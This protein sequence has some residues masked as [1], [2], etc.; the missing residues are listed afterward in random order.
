MRHHHRKRG[1]LG[2]LDRAAAATGTSTQRLL[3]Q[4]VQQLLRLASSTS[5]PRARNRIATAARPAPDALTCVAAAGAA[6]GSAPAAPTNEP[7]GSA[8]PPSAAPAAS[9]TRSTD[10]HATRRGRLATRLTAESRLDAE[11]TFTVRDA[12]ARR[13]VMSGWFVPSAR[14]RVAGAGRG[15]EA[16]P[17]LPARGAWLAV[18]TEPPRRRGGGGLRPPLE[19]PDAFGLGGYEHGRYASLTAPDRCCLRRGPRWVP[20]LHAPHGEHPRPPRGSHRAVAHRSRGS[21][22][23]TPR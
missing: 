9:A 13:G 12:N 7:R 15:Q 6:N 20:L 1:R 4:L 10:S 2:L 18:A 16:R 17:A 21:R 22:S 5:A 11:P 14:S 8:T 3:T 19:C 23:I